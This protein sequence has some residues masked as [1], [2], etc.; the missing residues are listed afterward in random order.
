MFVYKDIQ[1]HSSG[2]HMLR[3][4]GTLI[5]MQDELT[6]KTETDSETRRHRKQT[7]L[8]KEKGWRDELKVWD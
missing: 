6:Y 2:L 7:W 8:P 1:K 5:Q 4:A 3:E